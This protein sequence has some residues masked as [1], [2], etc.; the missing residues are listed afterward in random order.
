MT[1]EL[2]LYGSDHARIAVTEDEH[3]VAAAVEVL[4][5]FFVPDPRSLRAHLHVRLHQLGEHRHPL[6]HVRA[7][8]RD[9]LSSVRSRPSFIGLPS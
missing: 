2:F 5:S 1:I 6:G 7:V 9:G 4:G 8:P 3:A